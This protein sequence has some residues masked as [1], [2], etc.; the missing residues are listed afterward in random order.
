MN[1][2]TNEIPTVT[3]DPQNPFMFR[4]TENKLN[5]YLIGQ[6]GPVILGVRILAYQ[7]N[8][9]EAHVGFRI[10]CQKH[11]EHQGFVDPKAFTTTWP[12]IE[13]TKADDIRASKVMIQTVQMSPGQWDQ[14]DEVIKKARLI[15][16][17]MA[18]LGAACQTEDLVYEQ[19]DLEA[20]L[21]KEI[22]K[23]V[24]VHE[25]QGNVGIGGEVSADK[26]APLQDQKE[27]LIEK[28]KE[29]AVKALMQAEGL[30][31]EQAKE[32]IAAA[33]AQVKEAMGLDADE[34]VS[35]ADAAEGGSPLATFLADEDDDDSGLLPN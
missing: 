20:I 32:K 1:T 35:A 15:G 29:G 26:N 16:K 33:E 34:A 7:I 21:V 2:P 25:A 30:T 10:R 24:G 22:E 12:Q 31:E 17:L 11:P 14:L 5:Y 6:A 8:D 23:Q 3:Y 13:W 9:E 18:L 4:G 28:A 27:A 19:E